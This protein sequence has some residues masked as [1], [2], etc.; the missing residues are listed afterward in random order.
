[1]VI[2]V[3]GILRHTR[4][5]VQAPREMPARKKTCTHKGYEVMAAEHHLGHG[6]GWTCVLWCALCGALGFRDF[7]PPAPVME[8]WRK[9]GEFLEAELPPLPTRG[10]AAARAKR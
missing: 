5:C 3:C 1:M 10:K 4:A 9:V 7:R 6:L 8:R 2:V